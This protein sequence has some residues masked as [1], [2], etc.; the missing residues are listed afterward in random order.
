MKERPKREYKTYCCCLRTFWQS[1]IFILSFFHF[2]F[3]SYP[4][5]EKA[6]IEWKFARSKLWI[7]YFEDGGTVPPPFNIIPTP[8]SVFYF[9][10]WI[11]LKV[12]GKTSKIKK[13]HLKTVRVRLFC[14]CVNKITT[15]LFSAPDFSARFT[16]L[17][18]TTTVVFL[19]NYICIVISFLGTIHN[20]R[21]HFFRDFWHF[22]FPMSAVFFTLS[23]NFDPIL[24]IFDP[25]PLYCRRNLWMA[26]YCD[27]PCNLV[28]AQLGCKIKKIT[29]PILITIPPCSKSPFQSQNQQTT[30]T[31]WSSVY[32]SDAYKFLLNVFFG[33]M[34]E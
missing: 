8:K 18:S 25:S 23:A 28:I 11:Y 10:R 13:E 29:R 14:R 3:L 17:Y 32:A 21:R 2:S 24:T 19:Y 31:F 20:R 22:F 9:I 15:T 16:T 1:T 30:E 34:L 6:D 27:V 4:L 12:C 26:S 5:Q 7:S 33:H